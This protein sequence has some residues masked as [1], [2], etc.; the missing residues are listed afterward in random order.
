MMLVII[1][2]VWLLA[3]LDAAK[4]RDAVCNSK[5]KT[6]WPIK[7]D[8]DDTAKHLLSEMHPLSSLTFKTKLKSVLYTKMNGLWRIMNYVTSN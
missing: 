5:H 7:V 8:V 2:Y 4:R 3:E 6:Q 1:S